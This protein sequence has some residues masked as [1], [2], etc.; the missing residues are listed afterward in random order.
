MQFPPPGRAGQDDP[1][2]EPELLEN[3][4]SPV[5]AS[6]YSNYGTAKWDLSH[7]MCHR[8]YI[9]E[10]FS[11]S[12]SPV[13]LAPMEVVDLSPLASGVGGPEGMDHQKEPM[14]PTPTS[15]QAVPECATTATMIPTE[16]TVI[17]PEAI[18]Q[19]VAEATV[20]VIKLAQQEVQDEADWQTA[21]S[22]CNEC[23]WA[24]STGKSPG[25]FTMALPRH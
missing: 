21:R 16:S 10:T 25:Q 2:F 17:A 8:H 19:M 9:H 18:E 12:S 13:I 11:L 22:L 1:I 14:L 7:P 5:H 4:P 6:T 3:M 24:P 23:P 15:A 20:S